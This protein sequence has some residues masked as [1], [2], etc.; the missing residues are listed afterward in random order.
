MHYVCKLIQKEG[1]EVSIP[2]RDFRAAAMMR[3]P[4]TVHI[5]QRIFF[6][7]LVMEEKASNENKNLDLPR[8]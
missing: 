3:H 8:R 7:S 4:I 5:Q 6:S 1:E 2:D